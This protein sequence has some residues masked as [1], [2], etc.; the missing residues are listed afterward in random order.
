[1]SDTELMVTAPDRELAITYSGK[2]W[3]LVAY[4]LE[5][6]GTWEAT[7]HERGTEG[8][9]LPAS[10]WGVPGLYRDPWSALSILT[11]AIIRRAD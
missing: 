10:E 1:M 7:A 3:D 6:F 2:T 4:A 9:A 11:D 5:D 8:P